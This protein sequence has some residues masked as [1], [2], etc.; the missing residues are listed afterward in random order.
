[1]SLATNKIKANCGFKSRRTLLIFLRWPTHKIN[2]CT[3]P[4]EIFYTIFAGGVSSLILKITHMLPASQLWKF[5]HST[6]T[7]LFQPTF[8]KSHYPP[9]LMSLMQMRSW[10]D[11]RQKRRLSMFLMLENPKC[12]MTITWRPRNCAKH[13]SDVNLPDD[14]APWSTLP[15]ELVNCGGGINQVARLGSGQCYALSI[16]ASK[17]EILVLM[18]PN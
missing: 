9:T 15:N 14:W 12:E 5:R 16:W 7:Q 8:N 1:M 6:I 13:L 3:R 17:T 11:S 10:V 18:E 4:K 2:Y